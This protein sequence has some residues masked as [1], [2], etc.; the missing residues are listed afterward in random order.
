MLENKL[1]DSRTA[2]LVLGCTSIHAQRLNR[3]LQ[4]NDATVFI[5]K[6]QGQKK[7]YVF[8]SEI[9]SEMIQQFIANL[10]CH[11]NVSSRKL[12]ADLKERCNLDLHSH[13]IRLYIAKVKT[14]QCH[15]CKNRSNE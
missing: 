14:G 3:E 15:S 11:T 12:S 1:I 10:V 7:D 4:S 5:D 6:R 13:T 8:S 2:S 9:K